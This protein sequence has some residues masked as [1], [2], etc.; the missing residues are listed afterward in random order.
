MYSLP[1]ISTDTSCAISG[2]LQENM[3]SAGIHSKSV[4][5]MYNEST[6]DEMDNTIGGKT[7]ELKSH[8][9]EKDTDTMGMT[10]GFKSYNGKE[11]D[12]KKLGLTKP[13]KMEKAN[14]NEGK[15]DELANQGGTKRKTSKRKETPK[16][17]K[18]RDKQFPCKGCGK[19]FTHEQDLLEHTVIHKE[20]LPYQCAKCPARF[21]TRSQKLR[22]MRT[23]HLKVTIS[24]LIVCCCTLFSTILT[25][26]KF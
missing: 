5:D 25:D 19:S 14:E 6:D 23:Y 16:R 9:N 20:E 22:H 10:L 15:R 21:R 1:Y 8:N 4:E 2:W 11:L 17:K 7:A 24:K 13:T 18:N 3:S 12:R 26:N